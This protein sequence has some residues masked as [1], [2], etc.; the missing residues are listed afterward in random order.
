M[1]GSDGT[2]KVDLIACR[3][4]HGVTGHGLQCAVWLN[5]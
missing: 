2:W 4:L 3:R 5:C 1:I